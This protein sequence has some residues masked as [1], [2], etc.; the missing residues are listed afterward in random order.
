[1]KWISITSIVLVG[2][3]MLVPLMWVAVVS[4][5]L[6]ALVSAPF[7]L[8]AKKKERG[9]LQGVL[10][11][12]KDSNVKLFVVD[13]DLPMEM[14]R[15]VL[16]EIRFCFGDGGW[17]EDTHGLIMRKRDDYHLVVRTVRNQKSRF[18]HFVGHEMSDL[19]SSLKAA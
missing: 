2:S 15:D 16:S 6:I 7:I 8:I 3:I 14:A 11:T 17:I 10:S 1:M 9:H 19:M 12:D 13:F 5:P 18:T 4:A